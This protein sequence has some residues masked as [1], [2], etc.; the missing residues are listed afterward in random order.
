MTIRKLIVALL[1][2]LTSLPVAAQ[3]SDQI[4]TYELRNGGVYTGNMV[5]QT[6]H[7]TGTLRII[8]GTE[9]SG[10]WAMGRPVGQVVVRYTD[11]TVYEGEL[12]GLVRNGFGKLTW[13]N[14][15]IYEGN[16]LNAQR[17]G[18]GKMSTPR[19][20]YEGDWEAGQIY[21]RGTYTHASGDVYRGGFH[22]GLRHG[23]GTFTGID[24]YTYYGAWV[25]G[26]EEGNGRAKYP[27]GSVYVGQ[28]VK[29]LADGT[30]TTTVPATTTAKETSTTEQ[31][32]PQTV[33]LLYGTWDSKSG[34]GALDRLT[35][36]VRNDGNGILKHLE[37]D[38]FETGQWLFVTVKP[39]IYPDQ[40]GKILFSVPLADDGLPAATLGRRPEQRRTWSPYAYKNAVFEPFDREET[41]S[42]EVG[43][44][45]FD[46]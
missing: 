36:T 25:E 31:P 14:G 33:T 20:T 17:H 19:Y 12:V 27:D 15:F 34:D 7:G 32:E 29:G 3:S 9:Y 21:G 5:G 2:L 43:S 18:Q 46:N 42:N 1:C 40:I 44:W 13:P 4:V 24:G 28:F 38:P 30:G 8:D 22:H 26:K 6:F 23:T 16:W 35:F 37:I 41:F 11:G 45:L 39:A 10:N